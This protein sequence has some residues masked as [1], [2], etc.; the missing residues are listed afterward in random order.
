MGE[1]LYKNKNHFS[2]GEKVNINTKRP[3]KLYISWKAL[4]NFDQ[5]QKPPSQHTMFDFYIRVIE[6]N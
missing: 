6:N 5:F 2:E 4:H 1:A 3:R